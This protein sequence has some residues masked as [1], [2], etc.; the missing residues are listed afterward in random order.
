MVGQGHNHI[1]AD[2]TTTATMIP[3]KDAPGHIIGT[4]DNITGVLPGAHT[5]MLISTGILTMTFHIEGHLLIEA[6]Q[7]THEIAANHTHEQPTAS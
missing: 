3:T 7:L 5:Q 6:Q 2:T 1:L 4:A